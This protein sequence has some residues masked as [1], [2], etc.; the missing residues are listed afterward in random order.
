MVILDQ[1]VVKINLD[2]LDNFCKFLDKAETVIPQDQINPDGSSANPWK[3]CAM[4][5]V[6]AVKCLLRVIPI[7]AAAIT[8]YV[9]IVQHHTFVVFHA[10]QS[11][12]NLGKRQFSDP[13]YILHCILDELEHMD[14]YL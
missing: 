6:E 1:L 8:Y 13:S 4:Q 3:L 5:R 10:V 14:T 11:N 9:A 7:W 2:Q 12:R